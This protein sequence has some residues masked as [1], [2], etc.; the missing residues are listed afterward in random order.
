MQKK[1][2]S[3]KRKT[4]MVGRENDLA[5][6]MECIV[7]ADCCSVVGVSNIG[8]SILMRSLALP[9][10]YGKHLTSK[11]DDYLFVYID[12]NLTSQMSEQG[13]YE[14]ILRDMLE[15]LQ[16]RGTKGA[17]REALRGAY[18][19][20]ITSDSPFLIPLAFED[21]LEAVTDHYPGMLVLLFDE[22]DEVFADI[23][24]RVFVRLRAL[25]DRHW[26]QLCYVVATGHA[27]PETRRERQVGEFCELF[28]PHTHHLSPLDE[29]ASRTL[30]AQ[31]AADEEAEFTPQDVDFVLQCAG[32]H[33]AL[34][35]AT[36]RVLE[37]AK[38]EAVWRPASGNYAQ[39][40][41]QLNS[42]ANVRLECAKLWNDL[43]PQER[44]TLTL[45]LSSDEVTSG[46]DML[47][48]KGLVRSVGDTRPLP[49]EAAGVQVFSGLFEGFAK[50]QQL[51]RHRGPQ[52]VRIDVEAGDVW[53]DGELTPV[54]T[55]LEYKLLLLLYGN[56]DKICDKY[57]IVESVWGESY[58]DEV[59][60]ARIE[61]LVSR[62]RH[63]IEPVPEEPRYL[64]T[65]R[66]RGYRLVSP[67]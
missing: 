64:I 38:E 52:G 56:L 47:A 36:C 55:E 6:V 9:E 29:A 34:L 5:Y 66:G 25:K 4:E 63:K 35:M 27:L 31:W 11:K 22:F 2:S 28:A 42:N 23:D 10:V 61:K 32:G 15:L 65:I 59:D 14:V 30:V 18:E 12:F 24:A 26:P 45:L 3:M 62:L 13:F 67:E 46:L 16:D 41:E 51:M 20:V 43:S 53:V 37:A 1:P 48:Q 8:K 60:D 39:V 21:A 19:K 7:E 58:I 44:E 49:Q 50:R 40:R 57:Q 54:L 33:P 17:L